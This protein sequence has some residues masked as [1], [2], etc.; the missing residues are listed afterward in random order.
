[1]SIRPPQTLQCVCVWEVR[2]AHTNICFQ[3]CWLGFHSSDRRQY[4]G[5]LH[6][7]NCSIV[8]LYVK[9]LLPQSLKMAII[10]WPKHV[11]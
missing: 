8:V 10:D 4:S 6:F 9:H 2:G 5:T 3:F 7:S 1:M 11:A